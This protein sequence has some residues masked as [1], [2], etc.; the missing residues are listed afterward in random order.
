M[1]PI[2][3]I[4]DYSYRYPGRE[5]WALSDLSLSVQAGE[6][7]CF[8]GPSGCGKSTLFLTLKGLLKGGS[9]KGTIQVE[10]ERA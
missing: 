7:I 1:K 10:G 6:C 3:E 5:D 9:E 4:R 8:T 2:V